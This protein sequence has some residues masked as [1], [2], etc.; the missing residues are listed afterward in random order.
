MEFETMF[1]NNVFVQL[2]H[3]EKIIEILN[4]PILKANQ[5][6][7]PSHNTSRM[8]EK[9]NQIMLELDKVNVESPEHEESGHI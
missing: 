5:D 8:L 9:K 7:L 3:A 1:S 2:I 4:A 6:I